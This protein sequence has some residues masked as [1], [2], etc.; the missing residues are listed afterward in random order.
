MATAAT[1]GSASRP[2]LTLSIVFVVACLAG[3]VLVGQTPSRLHPSG[4]RSTRGSTT[5]PRTALEA[6]RSRVASLTTRAAVEAR[7]AEVRT[8]IGESLGLLP[9]Q[10]TSL[11]ATITRTTRREGYR[12]E[13][14]VFE[15]LPGL[16]VDG[17]RV[18]SRRRGSLPRRARH[19]R[20]RRRGQGV[21]DL[22]ARLDLARAA[23]LR[24][25]GVRPPGT[26]RALRVRR[27]GQGHVTCGP[28]H[29]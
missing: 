15:S 1:A 26:G 2:Y 8:A 12:I 17:A 21:T 24:G 22:S 28:R 11:N 19:R 4:S 3:G 20:A 7:Q 29:A 13:H 10:T 18:R 25:A 6:R 27:S 16:R 23:R 14:L 9:A 5:R